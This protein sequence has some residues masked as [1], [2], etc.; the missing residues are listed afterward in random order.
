MGRKPIVFMGALIH[1][2]LDLL[3]VIFSI[4]ATNFSVAF[5]GMMTITIIMLIVEYVVDGAAI[6]PIMFT[7]I[8]GML[9]ERGYTLIAIFHWILEFAINIPFYATNSDTAEETNVLDTLFSAI[10]F[11][12][13]V[14]VFYLLL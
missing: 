11:G 10:F 7:Y 3:L 2:I 6:S 4:M 12:V 13:S 9:P 14:L 8:I 1:V 5:E